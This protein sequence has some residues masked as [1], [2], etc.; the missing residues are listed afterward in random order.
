MNVESFLGKSQMAST[1]E[2][3]FVAPICG[4][5]NLIYD[6]RAGL[7]ERLEWSIMFQLQRLYCETDVRL[8]WIGNR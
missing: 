1:P 5:R 2:V 7:Q 4:E 3:H 8:D 6:V